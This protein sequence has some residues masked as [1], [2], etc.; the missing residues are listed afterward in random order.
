MEQIVAALIDRQPQIAVSTAPDKLDAVSV[1]DL[2]EQI[3]LHE[4]TI[5]RVTP[6]TRYQTIHGVVQ[7][8]ESK[9]KLAHRA[10]W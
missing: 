6:N 8:V 9:G 1:R 5:K 2:A 10:L 4:S 7:L 3:S